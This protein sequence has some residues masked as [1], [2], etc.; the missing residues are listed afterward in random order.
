[1]AVGSRSSVVRASEAKAGGPGFDS[2]GWLGF[3]CFFLLFF[4]SSWLTNADGMKD[5]RCYQH[6]YEWGEGSIVLCLAAINIDQCELMEGS[7]VL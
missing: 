5:L 6:R 2:G 1:M 3:F 7:M 4:F